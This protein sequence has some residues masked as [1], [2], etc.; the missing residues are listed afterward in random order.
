[1]IK[2]FSS[3][4]KI[5]IRG[6]I[7]LK[8]LKGS[9]CSNANILNRNLEKKTHTAMTTLYQCAVLILSCT[10][11]FAIVPYNAPVRSWLMTNCK[12]CKS[13]RIFYEAKCFMI[14]KI[15]FWE[16]CAPS[17]RIQI[18]ARYIFYAAQRRFRTKRN[19]W[20]VRSSRNELKIYMLSPY[21][22]AQLLGEVL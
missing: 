6:F 1:M 17:L 21:S 19:C 15:R 7:K 9:T 5:K 11:I 14:T 3:Q 4:S 16:N 18:T 12:I 8:S 20:C 10:V 22:E 13:E 2:A